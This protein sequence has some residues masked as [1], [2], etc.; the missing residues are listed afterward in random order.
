ML[1]TNISNTSST[2]I[3]DPLVATIETTDPSTV[4][5]KSFL[6]PSIS[7]STLSKSCNVPNDQPENSSI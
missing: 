4:S 6:T 2:L 7:S 1:L 3:L 5:G